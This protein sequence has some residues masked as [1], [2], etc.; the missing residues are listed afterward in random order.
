MPDANSAKVV[1]SDVRVVGDTAM[2]F[3]IQLVEPDDTLMDLSGAT[4]TFSLRQTDS[5]TYDVLNAACTI[6]GAVVSYAPAG[7]NVD[8]A[9]VYFG[10]FKVVLADSTVLIHPVIEYTIV[11]D[12]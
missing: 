3:A 8:T 2:A 6:N 12:I 4:A 10:R 11:A 5:T 9:G 1:C 7:V